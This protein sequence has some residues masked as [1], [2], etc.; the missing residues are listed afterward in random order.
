M[1]DSM[2]PGF[3]FGVDNE[4]NGSIS[5]GWQEHRRQKR[6]STPNLQRYEKTPAV[7]SGQMPRMRSF[8]SAALTLEWLLTGRGA[9]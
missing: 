3:K 9:E 4:E 8:V 5:C 7:I 6:K 1:Y 2:L